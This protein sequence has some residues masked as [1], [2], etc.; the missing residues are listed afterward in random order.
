MKVTI[1]T[2]CLNSASTIEKTIESVLA[3]TYSD[4]EYI[5][6]DG[7][8][9]DQTMDIINKYK[10][11]FHGRMKVYSEKDDGIY[12][13]V[14]KGIKLAQ[15]D[16]IGIINSDDWYEPTAVE[17]TISA[18]RGSGQN[19]VITY[20]MVRYYVGE[21]EESI[22]FYRHEHIDKRMIAH[23]TCFVSKSIYDKIGLFDTKYRFAADY[24]FMTRAYESGIY[25]L[26]IDNKIIANFRL[27]GASENVKSAQEELKIRR[28]KGYITPAVYFRKMTASK[29]RGIAIKILH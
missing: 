11:P 17:D 26:P 25:F 2:V 1:I 5:I 19:E 8:S 9:T 27:G 20:G 24:D 15:G 22:H 4:I 23:P 12:D 21:Q 14:N 10:E 29:I 3:Q 28:K 6:M 18:I 16:I 7:G 13:A